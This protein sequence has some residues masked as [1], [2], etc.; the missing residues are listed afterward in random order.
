MTGGLGGW[1]R[2]EVGG[3]LG[4]QD[5]G[6]VL[7]WLAK[8]TGGARLPLL[9]P[10]N[11][12]PPPF[13]QRPHC[14][15]LTPRSSSACVTLLILSDDRRVVTR[16][17]MTGRGVFLPRFALTPLGPQALAGEEGFATIPSRL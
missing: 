10:R 17:S 16:C 3:W 15:M 14:A 7:Q 6:G 8:G 12:P 9:P 11:P 4:V 13:A 5:V 2:G 1:A